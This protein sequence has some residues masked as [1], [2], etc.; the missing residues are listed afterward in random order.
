[1]QLVQLGLVLSMAALAFNTA[2]GACSGQV[3]RWLQR[4]PGAARFQSGLLAAVM[5]G[6]AV[7]LLF[8]DRP[9]PR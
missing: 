3:G 7:R 2:L 6:L 5:L 4:R 9:A 1:L 8:L